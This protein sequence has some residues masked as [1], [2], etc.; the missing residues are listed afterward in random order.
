MFLRATIDTFVD[1]NLVVQLV[2][3]GFRVDEEL[4]GYMATMNIAFDYQQS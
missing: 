3:H 1:I 2:A 4:D